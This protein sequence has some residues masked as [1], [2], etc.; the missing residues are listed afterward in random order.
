MLAKSIGE[1]ILPTVCHG[2][3]WKG[4]DGAAV[5]FG[6][7]PRTRSAS[8]WN[9]MAGFTIWHCLTSAERHGRPDLWPS[10]GRDRLPFAARLFASEGHHRCSA[11]SRRSHDLCPHES[12]APW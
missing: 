4:K 6:K 12:A 11:F 7:L 5:H 8:A 3:G 2:L 1:P 9:S 10:A